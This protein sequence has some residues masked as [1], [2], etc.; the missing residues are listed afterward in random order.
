MGLNSHLSEE[1]EIHARDARAGPRCEGYMAGR[2]GMH[3][4]PRYPPLKCT[5]SK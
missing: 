3:G 2:E 5:G 1:G 4:W